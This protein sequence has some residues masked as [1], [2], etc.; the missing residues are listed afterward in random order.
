MNGYHEAAK[1]DRIINKL[2]KS[3]P[4]SRHNIREWRAFVRTV[5]TTV[6]VIGWAILNSIEEKE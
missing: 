5:Q 1:I 4:P 6:D 3:D 2:L